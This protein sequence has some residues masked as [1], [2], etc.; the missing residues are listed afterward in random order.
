MDEFDLHGRGRVIPFVGV[1]FAVAGLLLAAIPVATT[2]FGKS[3][4]DAAA[5]E[6]H[7]AWLPTVFV[8]S[9]MLTGGA[10]L[11]LAGR[12][13]CGW[14]AEQRETDEAQGSQAR[15]EEDEESGSQDRTP[16]P[17]VLVPT[18]L[19][20]A[21]AIIGLIPGA[22][23]GIER[24]A[25]HF[26]DHAA[27]INW[28]LHDHVH[29]APVAT[30][31]VEAF[32]YLYGAAA[33]IGAVLVAALALFGSPLRRRVPDLVTRPVLVAVGGLRALHSGHIGDYIAWWTAGAAMFGGASLVL[34]R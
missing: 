1:V 21:A 28:V 13:F 33:T 16:L 15:D 4:L 8:I 23:P 20:L 6:G 14:G 5:L 31:H 7:Y 12:V 30:S 19:V 34:L 27:Y 3:L 29:F 11:R 24:A 22:V 17:M 26:R 9:S 18:I 32:D 25:A 2:F 10:V